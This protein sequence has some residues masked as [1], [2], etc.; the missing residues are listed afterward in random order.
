MHVPT[1]ETRSSN[2]QKLLFSFQMFCSNFW[3]LADI[4]T[5]VLSI[6]ALALYVA[7]RFIV[8][9]LTSQFEETRG[10]S[11]I[12]LTY[13]SLINQYYEYL[14]SM[15]VF[16]STVKFSKLLSFQKAFMQIG[17]TIKLCFQVL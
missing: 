14:V 12:R 6:A 11:Y 13:V 4:F 9:Q 15:T 2:D 17:A 8:I 16:T 5:M 3:N 7:K 1:P 10:N